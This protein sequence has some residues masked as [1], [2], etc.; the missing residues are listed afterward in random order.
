MLPALFTYGNGDVLYHSFSIRPLPEED[1][2]PQ[3]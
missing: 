2:E 1:P 3:D